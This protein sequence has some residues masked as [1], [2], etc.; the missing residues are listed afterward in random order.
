MTLSLPKL[1]QGQHNKLIVYLL[2]AV[3]FHWNKQKNK[4]IRILRLKIAENWEKFKNNERLKLH[5]DIRIFVILVI[6]LISGVLY[7]I[8]RNINSCLI[9]GS[10]LGK[11]KHNSRL[12]I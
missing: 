6:I 12:K 7:T 10:K 4:F 3:R 9:L 2:L 1:G 8:N 5:Q 11:F